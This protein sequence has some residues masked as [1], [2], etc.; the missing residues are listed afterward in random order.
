MSAL[1]VTH[2]I[3]VIILI[4]LVA[5]KY[6]TLLNPVTFFG[7]YFF[8]A[9]VVGPGL[10]IVL[11]LPNASDDALTTSIIL[12]AVYFGVFAVAYLWRP[13]PLS[14]LLIKLVQYTRPFQLRGAGDVAGLA[15]PVLLAEFVLCW[16]LLVVGS[17]AGALWITAP[18][19]A[20][21]SHRA[22][23]GVWWSLTQATLMLSFICCVFRFATTRKRT[24]GLSLG[25]AAMASM[26]GSKASTLAYFV[27]AL[28]LWHYRIG[29]IKSRVVLSAGAGL[30]A[31][32]VLTQMFYGNTES[33]LGA[34]LYFDYFIVSARFID[35]FHN[36]GFRWGTLALSQG[37]YYVPRALYPD[38][39]FGYGPS[40]ITEWMY[41]GAA[42]DGYT[43]GIL[44]WTAPYADFGV[45]GV[46]VAGVLTAWVSKAAYEYFVQART[47]FSAAILAQIGFVYYI[48]IFPNAPFLVFWGWLAVQAGLILLFS[49]V[50][51]NE[52]TTA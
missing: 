36:F 40:A 12:S 32:V 15:I 42:S 29:P 51:K 2:G 16:L 21:Q 26:L 33:I 22:G 44:Q 46:I 34:F 30:V 48:E 23:A 27:M 25:F 18:R 38:K 37:W 8:M 45:I 52:V 4:L 5:R 9:S 14:G 17:G 1:L 24:A 41:P 31:L 6:R 49:R 50:L 47:I 3:L 7:A 19:E 13:S 11:H 28:F 43:P 39:P 35:A 20:Y 10:Y